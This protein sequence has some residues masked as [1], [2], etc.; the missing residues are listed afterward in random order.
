MRRVIVQV[1]FG[2]RWRGNRDT[3]ERKQASRKLISNT[4]MNKGMYMYRV[5][6]FLTIL[7]TTK[8]ARKFVSRVAKQTCKP[9][10]DLDTVSKNGQ[11]IPKNH[12]WRGE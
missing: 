10:L 8:D 12:D 2:K 4:Q 1:Q 6:T 3:G 7:W 5:W 9:T 11:E